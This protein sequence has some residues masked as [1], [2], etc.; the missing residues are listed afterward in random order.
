MLLRRYSASWRLLNRAISRPLI[1]RLPEVGESIPPSRFSTVDF[2]APL[3]P[4]IM[5]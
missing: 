2:P 4:R 1:L 3:A 5:V